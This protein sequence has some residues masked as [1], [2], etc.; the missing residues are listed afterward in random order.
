MNILK[1]I[2]FLFLIISSFPQTEEYIFKQ[3]TDADGLS[4][5]TIFSMLQDKEGYLW[6]GT[7]DGLNRYDGYEF[8][9]YVNNPNDTTSIS[10]NFISTLFEDSE[11]NI[12]IGTVNGYFNCFNRKTE[13][14]KRFY[15]NNFFSVTQ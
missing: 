4:Q 13:I 8:R 15:V 9:V 3:F 11:G 5:S 12:W 6:L 10:D 14:F 7:I 1:I 2:L